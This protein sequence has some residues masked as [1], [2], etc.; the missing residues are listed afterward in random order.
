[1]FTRHRDPRLEQLR[2]I[3]VLAPLSNAALANIAHLTTSARVRAGAALCVQGRAGD[4]VFALLEGQV[5]ISRDGVPVAIVNAGGLVGEMAVLDNTL[6][7]ATAMTLTDV[8]ALV[9]SPREF[10]QL[11]ADHPDVADRIRSL[12]DARRDELASS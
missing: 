2:G 6:R 9:L 3:D 5:A 7:S 4:Q 10:A 12:G 8:S 1:M 11:L